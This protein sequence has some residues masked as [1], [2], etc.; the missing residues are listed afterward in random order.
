ME[1]G[2]L[3]L[4][5]LLAVFGGIFYFLLIRPQRKK[6]Q[7]HE[8][9]VSNLENGNEIVTAG[10]IHGSVTKVMEEDLLIEVED[11]TILKIQQDSI[12]ETKSDEDDLEVEEEEDKS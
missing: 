11:G 9:L 8:D 3:S 7:D 1:G 6:Q 2:A 10:G 5:I 4:I 12:V